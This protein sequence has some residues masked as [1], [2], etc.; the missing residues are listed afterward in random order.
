MAMPLEFVRIR[1]VWQNANVIE[2]RRL[3]IE[4]ARER[5]ESGDSLTG[6]G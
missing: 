5:V 3:E 1:G 4:A 6:H 2:A